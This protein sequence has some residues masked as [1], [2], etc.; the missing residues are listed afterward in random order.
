VS[1]PS[2]LASE[3]SWADPRGDSELVAQAQAGCKDAFEVLV[4]RYTSRVYHRAYAML[5]DEDLAFDMAQMAWIKAWQRLE[6]FA[7]QSL[8]STWMTRVTINVCLDYL[9][10][11]KRWR[12]DQSLEAMQEI[13]SHA[14]GK[15]PVVDVDP[16]ERLELEE[17]QALVDQALKSLSDEHR[18][19]ILMHTYEHMTYK[20]IADAMECS[21]GTV[22]SRLYYARKRMAILLGPLIE[23]KLLEK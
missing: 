4:H 16:L 15:L 6:Q 8:F 2:Q 18:S 23:G 14:E 20:E 3:T 10:K 21:I 11:S 7:G 13:D 19:V 1:D 12:F 22:M 5:R 9:R 17:K